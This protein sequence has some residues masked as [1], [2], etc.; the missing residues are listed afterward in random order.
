MGGMI[1]PPVEA[2][3]FLMADYVGV[4]Y[5]KIVKC[6][7]L[8]AILYF[9]GVFISVHL[10]AKKLG[11][12]GLSREQIP[13]M[14]PLLKK[15]YLLLPLVVLFYL[16]G[17]S[18]SSIQY[19]AAIAILTAIAVG[20]LNKDNRITPKRIVEALAAGAQGTISVAAACG[21]AGIIAGTITMTGLANMVVNLIEIGRAHV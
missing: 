9:G 17:S 1:W 19:A 10:E 11:L 5:S 6:A 16:I 13:A 4:P 15:L 7:I 12:K 2:E 21:I 3:A 20:L 18:R 8:P 14:K